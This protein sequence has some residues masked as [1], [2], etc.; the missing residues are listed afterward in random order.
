[1]KTLEHL[2]VNFDIG[3]VVP[4]KC[5][6]ILIMGFN[7]PDLARQQIRNIAPYKPGK[8]FFAVDGARNEQEWKLCRETQS[9]VDE[10][11]WPCEVKLLFREENRG[12]RNAPP[13]AIS[14]FFENVDSGIILEDDCHPAPDFLR[15]ATELLEYYKN[16]ERIGAIAA[17]NRYNI[18]ADKHCSYHFSKEF[19]VWGWASWRRVWKN[20]DVTMQRYA[21]KIDELIA[22]HTKNTRMRRYWHDAFRMTMEGSL[23]T[24]DYQVCCM[25]MAHKY[26]SIVPRERLVANMGIGLPTAVHTGGYDFFAHEFAKSGRVGFPL[27]HPVKVEADKYA[28]DH[29]ERIMMGLAWRFLYNAGNVLPRPFRPLLT[30]VGR[31][32]RLIAPWSFEL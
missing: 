27:I 28:D 6:P 7:R 9:V 17:F 15:F 16:D 23:N 10:I 22:N 19:N 4:F 12:C 18:Q 32:L 21:K 11:D 25:F 30:F 2:N 31:T 8:V 3:S 5:A 13:E 29:T 14:W 24:W 1:M 20:Y 26:F